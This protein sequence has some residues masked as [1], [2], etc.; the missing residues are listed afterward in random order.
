MKGVLVVMFFPQTPP[1]ATQL[2]QRVSSFT[3]S[4]SNPPSIAVWKSGAPEVQDAVKSRGAVALGTEQRRGLATRVPR[5]KWW[6]QRTEMAVT[7]NWCCGCC[8]SDG[9]PNKKI[10]VEVELCVIADGEGLKNG[11][12]AGIG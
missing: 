11:V 7:V 1:D 2:L 4:N 12:R 6:R 8:C 3:T 9:C 5:G 10:E